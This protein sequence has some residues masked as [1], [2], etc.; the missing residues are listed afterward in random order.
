MLMHN[1]KFDFLHFTYE[2]LILYLRTFI[3]DTILPVHL[4]SNKHVSIPSVFLLETE[5]A[6]LESSLDRP[7]KYLEPPALIENV[8]ASLMSYN[9]VRGLK[10]TAFISIEDPSLL[11]AST[12]V[13]LE[14]PLEFALGSSLNVTGPS[15]YTQIL[16][17]LNSRVPNPLFT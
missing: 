16:N 15:A 6:Q 9:H 3:F 7:C 10:A 11:E 14:K 1:R 5:K 17:D 13:A 12:L 2:R 4:S 8:T